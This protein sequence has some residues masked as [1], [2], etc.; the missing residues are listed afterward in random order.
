MKLDIYDEERPVGIQFFGG[1]IDTMVGC[2]DI[3]EAAKPD[4]IDINFGCPVKKV[5]CR[6]AG[7][8][9]LKDVPKMVNMT[10]EIVKK[11]S[12]PVTIKTR[13]GWDEQSKNVVEVAERL[14]DIGIAAISIHGRTRVQM[15]KGD[16]DWTLIGAVKNNP[17]MKIPVFLNG[18]VDTPEKVKKVKDEYGIDG[19]MIGRAAIGNPWFFNTVKHYLKTGEMLPDPSVEERIS[20]CRTHLVKEMEWKGDRLGILEMRRHYASYFKGLANVKEY[21]EKLVTADTLEQVDA[22]LQ[23]MINEYASLA[24]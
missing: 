6:G 18:D 12:L 8:G 14:Q 11:S 9:I 16:A 24:I 1:E 10:A 15:Y 2:V 5:A 19:V 22:V 13:L 4:L 20:V 7:A 21:R 23:S 17:R 3:I